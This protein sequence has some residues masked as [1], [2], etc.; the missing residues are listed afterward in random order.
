MTVVVPSGGFGILNPGM[1]GSLFVGT[2]MAIEPQIGLMLAWVGGE[3]VH[4]LNVVGQ[5]DYF[6]RG[7]GE[8]SLRLFA[9]GGVVSA[10]GADY[11]PKSVGFGAG[12]RIPLRDRLTLC[13]DGRYPHFTGEF[14]G[15][16]SDALGFTLSIGG[17]FGRM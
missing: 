2:R 5:F 9:A 6:I 17:V 1:Y 16:G 12:Y 8:R 14:D 3:S 13:V 15:G 4:F 10:S 7:T 11:T